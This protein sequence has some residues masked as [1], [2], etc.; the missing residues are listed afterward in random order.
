MTDLNEIL[1][2]RVTTETFTYAEVQAIIT[3]KN[4][5]QN[6][7]NETKKKLSAA[8]SSKDTWYKSAQER[9]G[10]LDQI[11]DILT[12]L[13]IPERKEGEDYRYTKYPVLTRLALF[14]SKKG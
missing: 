10:Q 2:A 12:A 9:E 1:A 7:L 5:L 13:G 6:E 3:D 11:H 8:E 4:T 14:I